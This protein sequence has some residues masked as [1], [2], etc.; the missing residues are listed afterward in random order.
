MTISF[1]LVHS[2]LKW[3]MRT[4]KNKIIILECLIA[5]QKQL[6]SIKIEASAQVLAWQS[7]QR[8]PGEQS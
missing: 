4:M 8:I 1:L 3:A 2:T 5:L 7:Q 6:Q